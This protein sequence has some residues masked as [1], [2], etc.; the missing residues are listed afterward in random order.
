MKLKLHKLYS[1]YSSQGLLCRTVLRLQPY[2]AGKP[3]STVVS[4]VMQRTPRFENLYFY[5]VFFVEAYLFPSRRI[6][7][8]NDSAWSK[9]AFHKNELFF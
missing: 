2:H 1:S 7:V 4:Y 8:C 6:Q 9:H 3:A 5:Y